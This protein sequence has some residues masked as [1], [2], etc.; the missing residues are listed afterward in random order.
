ML[1]SDR[2]T[3]S[4]LLLL[5]LLLCLLAVPV[6]AQARDYAITELETSFA[7][8]EQ[9]FTIEAAVSNNGG[10]ASADTVIRLVSVTEGRLV[11]AEQVITP[12]ASAASRNFAFVL[13]TADFRRD[14]AH[15][16]ELQAGV[17]NYELVGA[18]ITR[19][20]VRRITIPIPDS[21]G[22]E[23]D[24]ASF[25]S[26]N[27]DATPVTPPTA[28]P[29]SS[30]GD[31]TSPTTT[32]DDTQDFVLFRDNGD[33]TVTIA[34][35]TVDRATAT[36]GLLIGL[37]VLLLVW[38]LS[39]LL[40]LIFRRPP[41][42]RTWQPPY[43]IIPNLNPD[44]T[45]GRRQGWQEFAQNGSILAYA[46]ESAVHP[47]KR[48]LGDMPDR[49]AGWKVDAIRLVPYDQYGRIF[50]HQ[51]IAERSVVKKFSRILHSY[52]AR[53]ANRTRRQL[54]K[55]ARRL[56]TRYMAEMKNPLYGLPV[57]LD[58]QLLGERARV[59]ISFELYQYN[60]GR[61]NRIDTWTPD[62]YGYGDRVLEQVSYTVHGKGPAESK[63]EYRDRL[64]NDIAWLLQE[65]TAPRHEQPIA[66]PAPAG[67]PA[68]AAQPNY[69]IPDTLSGM[70]PI[71]ETG[72]PRP[73]D[74]PT[75]AHNLA[76]RP[77]PASRAGSAAPVTAQDETDG[78]PAAR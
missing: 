73:D 74:L 26:S 29:D 55:L 50:N 13:N 43:A 21:G 12:L 65:L 40:R 60:A 68:P 69:D 46:S 77:Q 33:D 75:A 1:P 10:A 66:S 23:T 62:L 22:D 11:V 7:A 71:E 34:S 9:T 39:L 72:E 31:V 52:N 3:G 57:A 5:W 25:S 24:I 8:D 70:R 19:N 59:D 15:Q 76:G 41:T 14:E 51:A 54:S 64:R 38:I 4:G 78:T 36:A 6:Q 56:A 63:R 27:P 16:F 47:V 30:A 32:G 35:Q 18:T 45:A 67:Q 20:N 28:V 2:L 53:R 42:F 44:S 17:D 58:V 49:W 61:W 37:G 48:L